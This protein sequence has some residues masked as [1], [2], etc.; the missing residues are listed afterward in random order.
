MTPII[1]AV[2]RSKR[3]GGTSPPDATVW[4]TSAT[5]PH[6]SAAARASFKTRE[7]VTQASRTVGSEDT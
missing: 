5:T 4:G 6:E 7:E 2:T 3:T 1:V